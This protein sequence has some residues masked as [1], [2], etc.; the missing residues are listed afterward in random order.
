MISILSKS[1][2]IMQLR[3]AKMNEK[4]G[5]LDEGGFNTMNLV[6]ARPSFSL[7]IFIKDNQSSQQLLI[8]HI[9]L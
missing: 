5:N 3:I 8:K 6:N 4:T 9:S 2:S 7:V 1:D